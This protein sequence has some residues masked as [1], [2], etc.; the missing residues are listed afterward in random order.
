MPH[1]SIHQSPA[2]FFSHPLTRPRDTWTLPLGVATHFQPWPQS[3]F[4]IHAGAHCSI[5]PSEPDWPEMS[6]W[7]PK[8]TEH[9]SVLLPWANAHIFLNILEKSWSSAS[10]GWKPHCSSWSVT[11][12]SLSSQ[13]HWLLAMVRT[14]ELE[15]DIPLNS[16]FFSY[17]LVLHS[18]REPLTTSC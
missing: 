5:K 7:S 10:W 2:A 17:V 18:V 9:K 11:K 8:A 4:L 15:W 14:V 12:D 3:N 1:Q 16:V 6:W 13:G